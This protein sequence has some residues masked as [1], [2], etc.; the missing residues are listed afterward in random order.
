MLFE[1]VRHMAHGRPAKAL[2]GHPYSKLTSFKKLEV[3]KKK[4]SHTEMR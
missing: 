4:S 1:I 3:V 2:F